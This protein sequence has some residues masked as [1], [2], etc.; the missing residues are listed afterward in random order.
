[1]TLPPLSEPF[2]E[3][4]AYHGS[5]RVAYLTFDDGPGPQTGEIL[6]ILAA[7]GIRATF[8]QVGSR[9]ADFPDTERR[10]IAGGHTLCNHSWSHPEGLSSAPADVINAEMAR[11]QEVVSGY[12]VRVHYFRA[13]GGDFGAAR[14]TLRQVCQ[15]NRVV[16][17]GWSV[18]S[19]DWRKPGPAAIVRNVLDEVAPGSVILMHDA[20]GAD[21]NQTI[22]A[23]PDVI[24]GLQ[25]AG[26]T[27]AALPA[28]PFG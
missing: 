6:D 8:C 19:Q 22:A 3:V 2:A 21:R 7:H 18:D 28:D 9:I 12:G 17:L 5:G 23:L 15:S 25:A 24:S 11:T 13:P 1:M 10:I 20:G 27:L 14:T 16:P 4:L 26:Y